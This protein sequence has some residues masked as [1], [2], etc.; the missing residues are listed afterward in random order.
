MLCFLFYCEAWSCRCSC[1][2]NVSVVIQM[3]YVCVNPV[4]VISGRVATRQA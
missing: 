3:L 2:G 4:A 1:M